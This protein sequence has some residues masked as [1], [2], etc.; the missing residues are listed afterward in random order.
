MR[1]RNY[2]PRFGLDPLGA[3][4]SGA[5]LAAVPAAQRDAAIAACQAAGIDCYAIGAV[6]GSGRWPAA[7]RCVRRPAPAQL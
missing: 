4:A 2:A 6:V 1:G 5:L 7:L 3:I